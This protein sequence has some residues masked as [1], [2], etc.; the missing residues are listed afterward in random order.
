[1][2]SVAGGRLA[3]MAVIASWLIF[4][5]GQ[6]WRLPYKRAVEELVL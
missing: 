4:S 6:L 1:M 5:Q 3:V 2:W